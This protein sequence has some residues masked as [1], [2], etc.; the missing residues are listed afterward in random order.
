MAYHGLR[1][2]H[3]DFTAALSTDFNTRLGLVPVVVEDLG[4]V[5]L[6]LFNNAFYAVHQKAAQLPPGTYAPAVSVS[7]QRV[8]KGVIIR[9]RDNGTGIPPEVLDKIFHP[10]FTTKPPGE[11]TGLGLSLSYDIVTQGHGG[12]L[13]VK[14]GLGEYTEFAVWLPLSPEASPTGQNGKANGRRS[15]PH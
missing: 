4:R 12:M 1:A 15:A 13:S 11:G 6:N 9:V 7:T 8:A 10:F 14:S 3:A 2:K 5:L